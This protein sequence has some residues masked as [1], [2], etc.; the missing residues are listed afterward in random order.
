[1]HV[2]KIHAYSQKQE[3]RDVLEKDKRSKEPFFK[4]TRNRERAEENI[5][6]FLD[7]NNDSS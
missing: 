7:E 5:S 3:M 6:G 1:M 4:S 2:S